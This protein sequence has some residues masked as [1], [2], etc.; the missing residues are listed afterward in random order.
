MDDAQTDVRQLIWDRVR[1]T[2][3]L[4]TS[5]NNQGSDT[6]ASTTIMHKICMW[7]KSQIKTD[8][9]NPTRFLFMHVIE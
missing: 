7:I 1:Y 4:I 8:A 9:C 6:T 3:V 5:A 2:L